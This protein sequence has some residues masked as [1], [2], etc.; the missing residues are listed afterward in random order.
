MTRERRPRTVAAVG[1]A[2]RTAGIPRVLVAF[3]IFRAA[4]FGVYI[5]TTAVAFEFGGVGEATAVLVAQ[6]LP[7]IFTAGLVGGWS[8]RWGARRVLVAGMVTQA[9]FM[10]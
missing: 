3:G 5:A 10:G 6:L 1:A 9:A 2:L 8:D 4:E 7:A